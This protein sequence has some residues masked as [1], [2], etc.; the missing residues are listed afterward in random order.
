MNLEQETDVGRLRQAIRL[1][2]QE[3]RKLITLNLQLQLAAADLPQLDR[4]VIGP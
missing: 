3:N 2:E 1:L 4:V